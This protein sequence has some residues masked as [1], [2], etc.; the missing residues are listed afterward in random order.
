VYTAT[1][2]V[3]QLLLSAAIRD[4]MESSISSLIAAG[5]S[6]CLTYTVAVYAFLSNWRW[7]ER[8]SKTCRSFYKNK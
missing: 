8:P 3:K 2:Y 7:T 4:E 1:V 5:S 6:R